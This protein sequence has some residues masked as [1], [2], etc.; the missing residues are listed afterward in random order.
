LFCAA[1]KSNVGG[2]MISEL[3]GNKGNAKMKPYWGGKSIKIVFFS[4]LNFDTQFYKICTFVNNF[5]LN[6][7][8]NKFYFVIN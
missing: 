4:K 7:K 6:F 8:L 5:K 3:R 1:S 2:E